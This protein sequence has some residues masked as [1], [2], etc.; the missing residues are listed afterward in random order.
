MP[1]QPLPAPFLERAIQDVDSSLL[2]QPYQKPH[3]VN[4]HQPQPQDILD[5]EQVPQIPAG[6]GG[7]GL[8]IALQIQRFRGTLERSSLDVEPAAGQPGGAVTPTPSGGL[9]IEE[10]HSAGDPLQQVPRKSD[11]HK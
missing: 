11:T 3:V 2:A 8:A 5:H 6:N 9:A 10:I 7:A 1:P 4:G